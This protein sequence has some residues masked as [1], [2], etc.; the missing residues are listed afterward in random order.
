MFMDPEEITVGSLVALKSGAV[1]VVTH[2]ASDDDP[3]VPASA[4]VRVQLTDE[5]AIVQLAY[6]E[7]ADTRPRG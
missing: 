7:I 3:A 1:G 4:P 6:E 2:I 5:G